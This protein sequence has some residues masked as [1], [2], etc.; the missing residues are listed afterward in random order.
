MIITS[1]YNI[2]DTVL[3][4]HVE[5]TSYWET[6][7]ECDGKGHHKVEGKDLTLKCGTCNKGYQYENPGKVKNWKW[8]PVVETLTIGQVRGKV[9]KGEPDEIDYM[10]EETGVGSGAVWAENRLWKV[11][12]RD[13]LLETLSRL[14]EYKNSNPQK[15]GYSSYVE[16]PDV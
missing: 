1:K 13:I 2:G 10:C 4:G 7:P 5:S 9:T 11:E 12:D 14:G 16:V 15:N 8:T 6:C 3:T